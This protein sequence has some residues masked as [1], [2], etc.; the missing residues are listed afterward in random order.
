MRQRAMIAMALSTRPQAADRRRAD[1]GARRDHPGAGDRPDEGPR[2]EFGMGIL[3]I[4]HDLGVVAQTATGGGDVSGPIVEK[5][6]VREV[7]RTPQ[8]PYT[9][10]LL[11]R[12]R[13][14]TISTRR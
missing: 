9:Q 12:C 3:F 13:S 6:P 10:G 7:I 1:H 8:H 4:T 2:A 14:S 5:G 11:A